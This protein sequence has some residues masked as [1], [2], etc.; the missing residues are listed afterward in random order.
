MSAE[1]IKLAIIRTNGGTQTRAAPDQATIDEYAEAFKLLACRRFP[2]SR[3][4]R[5][6]RGAEY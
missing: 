1:Q 6:N 5:E 2:P 3:G 4:S